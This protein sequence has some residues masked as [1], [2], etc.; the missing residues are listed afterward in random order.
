VRYSIPDD[1]D[2]VLS[3]LEETKQALLERWVIG[4]VETNRG[5]GCDDAS[6]YY[7]ELAM[8]RSYEAL[9]HES[10]E[11]LLSG[12]IAPHWRRTASDTRLVE[13]LDMAGVTFG[14]FVAEVRDWLC[15]THHFIPYN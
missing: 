15:T 10:N 1:D 3:E 7:D 6:I 2:D 8:R 4:Y 13:S 14:E 9:L 5:D 11:S 12:R